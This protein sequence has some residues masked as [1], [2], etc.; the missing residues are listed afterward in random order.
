MYGD[1]KRRIK[2]RE[3]AKHPNCP[4]CNKTLILYEPQKE[5][6]EMPKDMAVFFFDIELNKKIVCC[7]ECSYE[8][9]KD[10][11]SFKNIDTINFVDFFS[12]LPLKGK[13]DKE[14]KLNITLY[15]G[16]IKSIMSKS[17]MP[18]EDQKNVTKLFKYISIALLYLKT[19]EF[20]IY[21]KEN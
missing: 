10:V 4:Y 1:K 19:G 9:Q 2:Q 18:I 15:K 20:D 12:A 16:M 6:K 14:V 5:F 8:R 11:T 7:L 3:V 17:N 13:T 21:K